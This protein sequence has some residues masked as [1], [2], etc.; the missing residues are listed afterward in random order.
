MSPE[1]IPVPKICMMGTLVARRS[2]GCRARQ[3]LQERNDHRA[4]FLRECAILLSLP[5]R[6]FT[7]AR[8]ASVVVVMSLFAGRTA[9]R[10]PRA[11]QVKTSARRGAA[12]ADAVAVDDRHRRTGLAAPVAVGQY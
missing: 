12:D 2:Q 1:A 7:F 6:E 3:R 11:A 5:R 4:G 10:C 8:M 9:M